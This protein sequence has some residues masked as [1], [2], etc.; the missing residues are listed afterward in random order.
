MKLYRFRPC[1]TDEQLQYRIKEITKG[2]LYLAS[3]E[4]L[5]DPIDGIPKIYFKSDNK[6]VWSTFFEYIVYRC[7]LNNEC[8]M[9]IDRKDRKSYEIPS[10]IELKLKEQLLFANILNIFMLNKDTQQVIDYI[11]K[12]TYL[13]T[14][15]FNNHFFYFVYHSIT[16]LNIYY[17]QEYTKDINTLPLYGTWEELHK[18]FCC[19]LLYEFEKEHPIYSINLK[20]RPLNLSYT[21]CIEKIAK[22]YVYC[23]I[24]NLESNIIPQWHTIKH[25]IPLINNFTNELQSYNCYVGCFAENWDNASLWGNYASGHNGICIE[26]ETTTSNEFDFS[27][28]TNTECTLN[29]INYVPNNQL[30]KKNYFNKKGFSDVD[31]NYNSFLIYNDQDYL[32]FLLEN[33][34][35]NKLHE[36]YCSSFLPTKEQDNLSFSLAIKLL[37]I[38]NT[39]FM[40]LT[41]ILAYNI[42]HNLY[43]S[44]YAKLAD[45]MFL[46]N[47]EEY[48]KPYKIPNITM[49]EKTQEWNYE[50]EWRLSCTM[51]RKSNKS[52][53]IDLNKHIKGIIF[54][55][56]MSRDKK[57]QVIK[58]IKE[59]RSKDNLLDI[60][61]YEINFNDNNEMKKMEVTHLLKK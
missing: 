48:I 50:K 22:D 49:K 6:K 37:N 9:Y 4:E 43:N 52:V 55:S 38:P 46:K 59:A 42:L 34:E 41:S 31:T 8:S 61:L 35:L 26:Y 23:Y 13:S 1:A 16:Q 56:K 32:K 51:S 58:E 25:L 12:K 18:S 14:S 27:Y 29:Q 28:Q 20:K 15:D 17:V 30:S 33:K 60:K 10:L 11:T 5:N 54:G 39:K 57:Q 47:I 45:N 7:F 21:Y 2:E 40:A 53:Y 24:P 19:E 36:S 44:D 3:T